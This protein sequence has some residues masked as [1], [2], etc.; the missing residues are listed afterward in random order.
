M[1][2]ADFTNQTLTAFSSSSASPVSKN[3]KQTSLFCFFNPNLW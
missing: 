1:A 2:S 3:K